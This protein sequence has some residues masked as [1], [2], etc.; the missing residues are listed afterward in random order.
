MD[1][2]RHAA[3]WLIA[4]S[5]T[6]GPIHKLL[7]PINHTVLHIAEIVIAVGA[8]VFELDPATVHAVQDAIHQSLGHGSGHT[9]D[10]NSE[11]KAEQAK[12]EQ[13][14][15]E[16]ENT[17]QVKA[18]EQVKAELD[19]AAELIKAEMIKAD[20]ERAAAVI[21][22]QTVIVEQEIVDEPGKSTAERDALE[23]EFDREKQRRE[24]VLNGHERS[25]F[26]KHPEL[27]K[28][29][30]AEA[31]ETFKTIK[32]KEMENLR[33]ERET[34]LGELTRAQQEHREELAERLEELE[35]TRERSLR[36]GRARG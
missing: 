6:D 18:A 33:R 25:Y 24:E 16:Q 9:Q 29:Q 3:A 19:K 7:K 32:D 36:A 14:K 35:G 22:E 17:E 21:E 11:P 20:A 13:A 4:H 28:E 12:T 30:R 23:S 15:T 31:T 2:D 27:S 34:R 8:H 10:A 5:G 26:E 1:F